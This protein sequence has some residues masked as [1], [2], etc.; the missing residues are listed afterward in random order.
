MDF[1]LK[2]LTA[3]GAA[4]MPPGASKAAFDARTATWQQK[5]EDAEARHAELKQIWRKRQIAEYR[6][7]LDRIFMG[8]I[9]AAE[10]GRTLLDILADL[11]GKKGG[12]ATRKAIKRLRDA[13]VSAKFDHN[14]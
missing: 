9:L 14:D 2:H 5:I 12:S 10:T 7:T 8:K 13:L 4:P 1:P 3:T 6:R 11:D